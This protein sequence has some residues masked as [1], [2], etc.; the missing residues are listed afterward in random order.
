MPHIY[1]VYGGRCDFQQIAARAVFAATSQI[2]LER[3]L[4]AAVAAG[5]V[6]KPLALLWDEEGRASVRVVF[7]EHRVA[8]QQ[9]Y[10]SDF[11]QAVAEMTARGEVSFWSRSSQ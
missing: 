8:E 1:Y 10:I 11:S 6:G 4:S 3:E 9:A 7:A 2:L 5:D